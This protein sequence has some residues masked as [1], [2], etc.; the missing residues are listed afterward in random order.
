MNDDE[1]KS[2]E[3]WAQT[4]HNLSPADVQCTLAYRFGGDYD[5]AYIS[6]QLAEQSVSDFALIADDVYGYADA[7]PAEDRT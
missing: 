5:V 1:Y 7:P 4:E 6:K 3:T 2:L